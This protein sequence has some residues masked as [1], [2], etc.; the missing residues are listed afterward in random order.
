MNRK[1][2][3]L[4]IVGLILVVVFGSWLFSFQV[5]ESE[6]AVVTTF[7]RPTTPITQAGWHFRLPPP[8]QRVWKFDK[9]VQNFEDK[10]SEGLTR[11]S[12][13]VLTSVFVGW[14]I[15]EPTDF[16]PKFAGTADPIAEAEKSLERVLSN[17]KNAV[18]GKHPLS[19]FVSANDRG[20]NFMAIEDEILAAVRAQVGANRYGIGVEFLGLKK[21]Q[22]PE[23]VTKDVFD[24]MQAE[25][26]V[27][28]TRSQK[29]GEAEAQKIRSEAERKTAETLATA[30]SEA[31][32]IKGLAEAEAAKSLA[33][34]QQQPDLAKF[35]FSLDALENALKDKSTLVFDRHT[36]PFD[37]LAGVS[38]NL[39]SA[40]AAT[41]AGGSVTNLTTK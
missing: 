28:A 11:D 14:K 7:G 26:K 40:P 33:V 12:F 25:R 24:R 36:P 31:T 22:L 38:S 13:N 35:I 32:R 15:T 18:V 20:T 4:L 17:V 3:T 8:I 21:L 37:L 16:Y 5:R 30:N 34:F 6:I 41:A 10:L 29:E 27:L 39:L 23:Q 9:R 2:L 19:D 1:P